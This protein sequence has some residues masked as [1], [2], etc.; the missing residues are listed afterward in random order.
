[1]ERT[2]GEGNSN[3]FALGLQQLSDDVST[4]TSETVSFTRSPQFPV[5]E[6]PQSPTIPSF[7][8]G[9]ELEPGFRRVKYLRRRPGLVTY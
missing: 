9:S 1:M 2:L 5:Q 7:Q 8:L 4:E 6:E 3:E